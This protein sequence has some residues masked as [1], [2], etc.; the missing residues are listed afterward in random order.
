MR[1]R[2]E[3]DRGHRDGH[4]LL[5]DAAGPAK[6]TSGSDRARA[7]GS[8]RA[9]RT[10]PR[11]TVTV[12][13]QPLLAQPRACS[14]REA[15]RALGDARA[16]PLHRPAD[17]PARRAQVLAPVLARSTPRASRRPAG[18][19]SQRRRHRR[20]QQREVGERRRVRRRRSRR[21]WR[22]RCHSTPAPNTSG[23][24]IRRRPAAVYSAIRGPA[25]T[26]R[27]GPSGRRRAALPLAQRQVG[28]LVAL[29]A[30]GA[31]RGCGTSARRRRRCRG[32]GSR[33]RCRCAS[34]LA[35]QLRCRPRA[36]RCFPPA[37]AL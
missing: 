23:G 35:F 8:A 29:V 18:S 33:R 21:P 26:T 36:H 17:A 15:E 1:S 16:Q 24:R 14:S 25:A 10:R 3:R 4:A 20:G 37:G 30:P 5:R 32:T 34:P 13:A 19:R 27:T 2:R 31:P 12:A 9:P 28:D 6:T 7:A 22:S 11:S